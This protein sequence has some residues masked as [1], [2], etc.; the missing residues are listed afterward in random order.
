M[1]DFTTRRSSGGQSSRTLCRT[2]QKS[3]YGPMA[4]GFVQTTIHGGIISFAARR[5]SVFGCGE[6][7]PFALSLL[8]TSKRFFAFLG[9]GKFPPFPFL[10]FTTFAI[11]QR[12][13]SSP[14]VDAFRGPLWASNHGCS[15][16]S[17]SGS[18]RRFFL[19]STAARNGQS[20]R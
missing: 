4:I 13:M 12:F 16:F 10:P 20:S 15:R 5:W 9:P 19:L 1:V 7:F 18:F 3:F 2:W 8:A 14:I 6:A 17:V 11:F